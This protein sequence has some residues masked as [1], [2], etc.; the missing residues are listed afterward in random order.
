MAARFA[1]L[2]LVVL[3]LGWPA[4][5]AHASPLGSPEL[6]WSAPDGCPDRE[7]VRR[8]IDRWLRRSVDDVDGRS[9]AV[10][11]D[12]HRERDRWVLE[13]VLESPSGRAH[14]RLSAA[15]CA[16]LAEVVGLEVALAA[17]S[18][19]VL[20]TFDRPREP[21]PEP[22]PRHAPRVALRAAAGAVV[23]QLPDPSGSFAI[24]GVLGLA[25]ARLE[26]AL[27]YSPPGTARYADLPAVGAELQ[28]LSGTVRGCAVPAFGA[29]ELPICLGL[30]LGAMRGT[31]FGTRERFSSD[32]LFGAIVLGPALRWP[33][34]RGIFAWLGTDAML[35]FARPSYHMRNLPRLYRPDAAA[36]RALA[37]I[38]AEF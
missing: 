23:G 34:G 10:T 20:A 14:E 1:C 19:A 29:V 24:A 2:A 7:H 27:S 33:F 4:A 18:A 28:L 16:T 3:G 13:L 26:L 15:S 6:E 30:E 21:E 8:T 9:I 36:A 5:A 37:G 31:G 35:A 17:D 25:S 38:E 11:A 22:E 12:V 32:Q